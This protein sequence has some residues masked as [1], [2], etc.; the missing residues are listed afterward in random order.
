MRTR[1]CFAFRLALDF[2]VLRRFRW[3]R[4]VF[5]VLT[6]EPFSRRGLKGWI[7]EPDFSGRARKV[8]PPVALGFAS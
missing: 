2:A 3:D 4:F 5:F 6:A 8:H 1:L 7:G